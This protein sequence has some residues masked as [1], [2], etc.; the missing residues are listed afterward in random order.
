MHVIESL[1]AEG[2]LLLVFYGTVHVDERLAAIG[3]VVARC[4]TEACNGVLVDFSL[5]RP[6]AD[7]LSAANR[8]ANRLAHED[9][10]ASCRVAYVFPEGL[11]DPTV[12]V[13]ASAKGFQF[14]RF[15][16]REAALEWLRRRTPAP[17]GLGT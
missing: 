14:G 11:L 12:D 1:E 6:A 5:A 4:R 17:L 16:T 7:G 10:F 9:L 2:L 13:L 3:E 8:L 15:D